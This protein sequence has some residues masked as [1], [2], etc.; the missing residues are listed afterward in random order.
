[1]YFFSLL[2]TLYS[3]TLDGSCP[4]RELVLNNLDVI[5]WLRTT[6]CT[7]NVK[8]ASFFEVLQECV[9]DRRYDL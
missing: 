7:Q 2:P 3:K 6:G 5:H 4:T 9:N 8:L 1:M